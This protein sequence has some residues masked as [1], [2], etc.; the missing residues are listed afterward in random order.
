MEVTNLTD[1]CHNTHM[2]YKDIHE[3]IIEEHF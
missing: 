1:I 3:Q 2:Q